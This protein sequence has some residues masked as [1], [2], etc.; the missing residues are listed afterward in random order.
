MIGVIK[1]TKVAWG[2]GGR[3]VQGFRVAGTFVYDTQRC[4][5]GLDTALS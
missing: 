2:S 5:T 3:T 4:V 1:I